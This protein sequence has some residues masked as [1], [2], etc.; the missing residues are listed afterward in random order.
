MGISKVG[1]DIGLL[2]VAM[3][4]LARF[5]TPKVGISSIPWKD[6]K[7]PCIPWPS[8]FLMGTESEMCRD[9]VATGSFDKTAKLW[10]TQTGKLLHTFAGHL[11]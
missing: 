5:G 10:D 4:E 9:R 2:L 8:T 1:A 7:M 6:I 11:N 3:I